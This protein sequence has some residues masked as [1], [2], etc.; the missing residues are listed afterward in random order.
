MLCDAF[1]NH[2]NT[3]LGCPQFFLK[4][5]FN[6]FHKTKISN[7]ALLDDRFSFQE[8]MWINII[9]IQNVEQALSQGLV[10]PS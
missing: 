3:N 9:T 5:F 8:Q 2:L 10:C 6:N 1:K 4:K 7:R